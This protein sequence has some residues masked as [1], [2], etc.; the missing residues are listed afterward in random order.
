M[1]GKNAVKLCMVRQVFYSE[2]LKFK[3]D[4][5]SY[6][7]VVIPGGV[8]SYSIFRLMEPFKNY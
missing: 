3:P 2:K 1:S 8:T 5:E 4:G 6:D 7:L